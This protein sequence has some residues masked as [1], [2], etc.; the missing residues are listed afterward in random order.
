MVVWFDYNYPF[1]LPLFIFVK[2]WCSLVTRKVSKVLFSVK[3]KHCQDFLSSPDWSHMYIIILVMQCKLHKIIKIVLRIC[4]NFLIVLHL[5]QF[6]LI[7][8]ENELWDT[9]LRVN[10]VCLRVLV[11]IYTETVTPRRQQTSD[12]AS[13]GSRMGSGHGTGAETLLCKEGQPL[14]C[15]TGRGL[16]RTFLVKT[17]L[18]PAEQGGN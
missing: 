11:N 8:T 15:L 17:F 6:D 2:Q 18:Q 14:P 9:I 4:F 13:L 16:P 10:T 1:L 3:A 7:N 12:V 5:T